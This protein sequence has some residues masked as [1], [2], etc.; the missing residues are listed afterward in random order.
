MNYLLKIWS[1]KGGELTPEKT[2]IK[3]RSLISV[4]Y[5]NPVEYMYLFYGHVA[6]EHLKSQPQD[7]SF[8]LVFTRLTSATV[9]SQDFIIYRY[10]FYRSIYSS[11]P[12]PYAPNKTLQVKGLLTRLFWCNWV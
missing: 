10:V 12:Q 2:A 5:I 7:S 4:N 1:G 9:E 11:A 3:E 8:Q 6:A